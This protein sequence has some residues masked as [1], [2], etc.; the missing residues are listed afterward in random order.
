[1]D[2]MGELIFLDFAIDVHARIEKGGRCTWIL[3]RGLQL[4]QTNA[5][6]SLKLQVRQ[7]IFIP[8][9]KTYKI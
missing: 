8:K 4:S 6:P 1:M 2:E 7:I 3:M 5:H 9:D